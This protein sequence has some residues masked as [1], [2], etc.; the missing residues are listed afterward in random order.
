MNTKNL[1][2]KILSV[3]EI[4]DKL[5]NGPI[6]L[7]LYDDDINKA[8]LQLVTAISVRKDEKF[9]LGSEERGLWYK[10]GYILV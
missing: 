9:P 6:K 4:Y 5:K 3:S 2:R 1:S 7:Y 10:H 8:D